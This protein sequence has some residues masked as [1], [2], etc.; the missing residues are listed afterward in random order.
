MKKFLEILSTVLDEQIT[1]ADLCHSFEELGGH[2]L[3]VYELAAA[4]HKEFGIDIPIDKFILAPSMQDI[5]AELGGTTATDGNTTKDA[6]LLDSAQLGQL[7]AA[8]MLGSYAPFMLVEKVVLK[9][10]SV[11]EAQDL[12]QRLVRSCSAIAAFVDYAGKEGPVLRYNEDLGS[13]YTTLEGIDISAAQAHVCDAIMPRAASRFGSHIAIVGMEGGSSVIFFVLSHLFFDGMSVAAMLAEVKSWLNNGSRGELAK[14]ESSLDFKALQDAYLQTAQA[15]ADKAFWRDKLKELPENGALSRYL[16][17]E[18]ISSA[19]GVVERKKLPATVAAKFRKLTTDLGV[20]PYALLLS[21]LGSALRAASGQDEIVIGIPSAGR[22][23]LPAAQRKSAIGCFVNLLPVRLHLAGDTSLGVA[24]KETSRALNTSIAHGAYP[25]DRMVVDNNE[26]SGNRSGIF[27]VVC[28][29][30]ST[31]YQSQEATPANGRNVE[32]TSLYPPFAK[33]PLE[34]IVHDK[35]ESFELIARYPSGYL[36]DGF[37][38]AL[39]D[40]V[41]AHIDSAS[42]DMPLRALPLVSAESA[43]KLQARHE[44][45]AA[46]WDETLTLP[47]AL[48]R[49]AHA[50]PDAG[51]VTFE[52]QTVS[53]QEL[54]RRATSLAGFLQANGVSRG[55]RVGLLL[56]RSDQLITAIFAVFYCGAAYVPVDVMHPDDRK[57][58]ILEDA[59]C[60]LVLTDSPSE[61]PVGAWHA[62]DIAT[63]NG[64][65]ELTPVETDASDLAYVIYT[66]GTTGKPKGVMIE[67]RNVVRLLQNSEVPYPPA[68]GDVVSMFH[69]HCFDVSVFEMFY[70]L[71]YGLRLVVVPQLVIKDPAEFRSLL[72]RE[73]VTVLS[74]TPTAFYNLVA[75]ESNHT[76]ANL[77]VRLVLFAGEALNPARIARWRARYPQCELANLYGTTET[78]VHASWQVVSDEHIAQN[79]SAIGVA[80]PTG[81]LYLT[82]KDLRLVP[83]G[84]I[85]ELCIG[86][87][88]VGR[89]YLNRPEETAKRFVDD[90]WTKGLRLY[91][92]GDVAYFSPADGLVYVGRNDKQVQVR[93]HRV[94]PEE[95]AITVRSVS[96]VK[97]ALVL[98]VGDDA[99]GIELCC[100]WVGD[101]AVVPNLKDVVASILPVY[102]VP[103]YFNHLAHFPLTVNGKIDTSKLP[104]P[105]RQVKKKAES[106]PPLSKEERDVFGLFA[107]VL[108]TDAFGVDDDFFDLGGDSLLAVKLSS[109]SARRIRVID[110][111]RERTVARLA[112]VGA[113]SSQLVVGPLVDTSNPSVSVIACPFAGGNP[114]DF[115][116]LATALAQSAGVRLYSVS[117]PGAADSR[118]QTPIVDLHELAKS[119]V[120]EMEAMHLT[121]SR[122]ALLGYCV[123]AGLACAIA[124]ELESRGIKPEAMSLLVT[125]PPRL[126]GAEPPDDLWAGV[127]DE[128]LRQFLTRLGVE[129]V[130]ELPDTV[131]DDYRTDARLFRRYFKMRKS[132]SLKPI[133]VPTHLVVARHDPMTPNAD[134]A[135]EYWH[136]YV[137]RTNIQTTVLETSDHYIVKGYANQVAEILCDSLS[138]E[139]PASSSFDA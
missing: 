139:Q 67:H 19:S 29:F 124:S 31:S 18:A 112:R 72:Q 129:Q 84:F 91:R 41:V 95:V 114:A 110:L 132:M 24:A 98:P 111:Y 27:D 33:Y 15:T 65:H 121:S 55:D 138:A 43:Q 1:Q 117:P 80:L 60:A 109:I 123:G 70:T 134:A 64:E 35:G 45:Y 133:D 100:Y 22:G 8:E 130:S 69:S 52:G 96:G 36:K 38:T 102:M 81:S 89:G 46:S 136:P 94:E 106:R 23:L 113:P 34:I 59:S 104:K 16:T 127:T 120:D 20:S 74:Q 71:M 9:E 128:E 77:S 85:G 5:Y 92:S 87:H 21:V 101:S 13:L 63:N 115:F 12:I 90:P 50:T 51:A 2:S 53:Y 47:Q 135:A 73:K 93:G 54:V 11:R 131:L 4:L 137:V 40:C 116:P 82:D 75:E 44:R 48:E 56:Q 6:G 78:T 66:S 28:S 99:T 68:P 37:V 61:V 58:F 57:R 86:G 10:T 3:A 103:A 42:P 14:L 83:H 25:Y 17:S 26:Q 88:G 79:V 107:Q 30:W 49:V 32:T 108:G 122:V 118:T 39:L 125:Y 62:L 119:V 97:D 7:Y 76:E 105:S 126:E